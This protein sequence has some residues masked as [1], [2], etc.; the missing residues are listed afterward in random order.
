MSQMRTLS[1]AHRKATS[2]RLMQGLESLRAVTQRW[3]L[4]QTLFLL[5]AKTSCSCLRRH[6]KMN[7]WRW[8][9][10]SRAAFVFQCSREGRAPDSPGSKQKSGRGKNVSLCLWFWYLSSSLCLCSGLLNFPQVLA[11]SISGCTT[12]VAFFQL[13]LSSK[14]KSST[15]FR[16]AK[17]QCL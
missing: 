5:V 11:D 6:G 15:G 3:A 12:V 8:G 16:L 1:S 10:A 13:L 4:P 14:G 7:P 2:T 17:P 9:L